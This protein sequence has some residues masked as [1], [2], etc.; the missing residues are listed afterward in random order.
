M[1]RSLSAV[2]RTK[3]VHHKNIAQGCVSFGQLFFVFFLALVK[4]HVFQQHQLTGIN[5]DIVLPVLNHLDIALEQ[6]SQTLGYRLEGKSFIVLA[7]SGPSEMRH[8]QYL[9]A[10]LQRE[11]QGRQGRTNPRIGSHDTVLYRDIE[12]FTDQ[13]PLAGQIQITHFQY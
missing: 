8:H 1:G 7:F 4:A 2:S 6:F 11:L 5:T 13:D 9:G 3:G 10:L 12:I